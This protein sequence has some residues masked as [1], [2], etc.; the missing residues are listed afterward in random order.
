M[1]L[2]KL[3]VESVF[4]DDIES[5]AQLPRSHVRWWS[6]RG[7]KTLREVLC[8]QES[9]QSQLTLSSR[10]RALLRR[11]THKDGILP[12]DSGVEYH[13]E[14]AE[15]NAIQSKTYT[16]KLSFTIFPFFLHCSQESWT[17]HW[18][19]ISIFPTIFYSC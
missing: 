1:G 14:N 6:F 7:L 9:V 10:G 17:H 15:Y 4:S 3:D 2:N 11:R 13:Q 12:E 18:S 16:Q 8:I 19:E 5:A